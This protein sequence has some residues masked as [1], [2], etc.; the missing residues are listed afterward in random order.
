MAIIKN[1]KVK[2]HPEQKCRQ[3]KGKEKTYLA[4]I[5]AYAATNFKTTKIIKY[6]SLNKSVLF[7]NNI[8]EVYPKCEH[9]S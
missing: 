2:R 6:S 9:T 5:F 4:N 1:T 3:T 8:T 7:Q